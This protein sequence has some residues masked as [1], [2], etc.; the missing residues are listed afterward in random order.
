MSC[1]VA[2]RENRGK[3]LIFEKSA[4]MEQKIFFL[5]ILKILTKRSGQKLL[6]NVAKPMIYFINVFKKYVIKTHFAKIAHVTKIRRHQFFQT[7][8]YF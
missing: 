8:L 1:R 4:K 3:F 5:K 7:W 2:L 6:R